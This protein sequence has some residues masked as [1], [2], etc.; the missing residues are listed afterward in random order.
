MLRVGRKPGL[1]R[2]YADSHH[3]HHD[4][5]PLY[6]GANWFWVSLEQWQDI[7]NHQT[8]KWPEGITSKEDFEKNHPFEYQRVNFLI[9]QAMGTVWQRNGLAPNKKD[10]YRYC[11]V[12]GQEE[13]VQWSWTDA[14]IRKPYYDFLARVLNW[15]NKPMRHMSRY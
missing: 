15:A 8:F 3:I 5:N 4:P 12:L 1:E 9:K 13:I 10:Y 11:T 14:Y 6:S 2:H 7:N